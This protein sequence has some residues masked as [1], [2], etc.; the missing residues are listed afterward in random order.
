MY[1]AALKAH[2]TPYFYCGIILIYVVYYREYQ[3]KTS[4]TSETYIKEQI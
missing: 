2:H 1:I 4:G 3:A